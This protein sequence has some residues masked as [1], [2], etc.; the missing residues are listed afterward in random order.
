MTSFPARSDDA[1]ALRAPFHVPVATHPRLG[2]CRSVNLSTTGLALLVRTDDEALA[3][4]EGK[5]VELSFPLPDGPQVEDRGRILW[6]C[7][8][9]LISS[10]MWVVEVLLEEPSPQTR[11]ALETYL[12]DYRYHVGVAGS[13]A[14]V[15]EVSAALSE[16][17]RLHPVASSSELQRLVERGDLAC[18]VLCGAEAESA[19]AIA[20]ENGNRPELDPDADLYPRIVLCAPSAPPRLAD[21]INSRRLSAWLRGAPSAQALGEAVLR[22]CGSVGARLEEY[23]G[24]LALTR[25]RGRSLQKHLQIGAAAVERGLIDTATFAQALLSVARQGESPALEDVWLRTGRLAPTMLRNVLSEI[26]Q[27]RRP[28]GSTRPAAELTFFDGQPSGIGLS[29][30]LFPL[31]G[32]PAGAA[33]P[34]PT[35]TAPAGAAPAASSHDR[36]AAEIAPAAPS[37]AEPAVDDRYRPLDQLGAGGMGVV[38]ECMDVLLGRRVALKAPRPEP[39]VSP[40]RH[41]MLEREARVT[42]L[43]EHPNIIPVYDTGRT[44]DGKP[45]YVM[46]LLRVPTL[47]DVLA[48]LKGGDQ[49]AIGEYSLGRLLRCFV[50][51]CQAVDYAHTR[52]VIHCDLKPANILLGWFGEVVVVDWGLAFVVAEGTVYRGGTLGYMAPEQMQMQT[53]AAPAQQIDARTDIY[54]LGSI[55]YEILCLEPAFTEEALEQALRSAIGGTPVALRPMAPRERRPDREVPAELEEICQKAMELNRAA[56]FASA[57]EISTAIESFLEGTKERERRKSRADELVTLGRRFS[58]NYFELLDSRPERVEELEALRASIPPWAPPEQKRALWEVEDRLAVA[59]ALAV[60]TLQ[61][62]VFNYEQALEQFPHDERARRGLAALYRR[63]LKR[64]QERRDELNRIYFEE[65]LRQYDDLHASKTS[66]SRGAISVLCASGSVDVFLSVVEERSRRLAAIAKRHLGKTPLQKLTVPP[67]NY[68]V[69]LESPGL[70]PVRYPLV[71]KPGLHIKIYADRQAMEDQDVGE[72]LVPGGTA[73]LGGDQSRP[74]HTHLREIHIEPFYIDERPVTFREYLSFVEKFFRRETP[75]ATWLLP[76]HRDGM[77]FWEWNG[78][79][80]LP[81]AIQ[82]WGKDVEHLLSLPA[83]GVEARCAEAYALWRSKRTGRTYRLPSEP[84]WEKAGRGTDGRRY[85]WGDHFDASF[86]H[87]RESRPDVPRPDVSRSFENDVSPYG[88]RDMA[89]C[90]ADWVIPP[91]VERDASGARRLA[92]RG[93]A[94]CDWRSECLLSTRR[95]YLSR[96]SSVRVGFRLVRSAPE[97]VRY[98]LES[99]SA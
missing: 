20:G 18:L 23:R 22:A 36:G 80:F 77:P 69:T 5:P 56:R 55:L 65:L 64:A 37:R 83:F 8:A 34:G 96:E 24:T 19:A 32:P 10:D 47:E 81:A 44:A 28:S 86:C 4:G 92:A 71:I 9:P 97:L 16:T 99:T 91:H 63:E 66:P 15:A 89:G 38:T 90:I 12:S 72:I 93:G 85:P 61:T 67:G 31:P 59:D 21:L 78:D 41:R 29:K 46:R 95:V 2:E 52:G 79:G 94:W 98:A 43:L 1:V 76:R 88:V 51:V 62:A 30:T 68:V 27:L 13:A 33:S 26:E 42:G 57:R 82:R 39:E 3:V 54:A 75:I 45:F 35:P 70:P 40:A 84:E 50:Q 73:L 87:M 49:D 6:A 53:A 48:C 7:R 17:V 11:L 74:E 25:E 58:D 14:E 60:R